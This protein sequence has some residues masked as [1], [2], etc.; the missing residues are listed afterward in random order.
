MYIE[1]IDEKNV[2]E[3]INRLCIYF[4]ITIFSGNMMQ[5]KV[6]VSEITES[7]MLI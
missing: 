7:I 4:K 3:S 2:I 1:H 6:P 5:K